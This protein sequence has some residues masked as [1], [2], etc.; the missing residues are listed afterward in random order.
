MESRK[1]Q[2]SGEEASTYRAAADRLHE[3]C[4]MALDL[5]QPITVEDWIFLETAHAALTGDLGLLDCRT[6][7]VGLIFA[8]VMNQIY[9]ILTLDCPRGAQWRGPVSSAEVYLLS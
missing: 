9:S 8:W 1:L 6:G 7:G 4:G 5:T 2:L 3:T